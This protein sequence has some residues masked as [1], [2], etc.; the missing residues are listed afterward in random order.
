LKTANP[1]CVLEWPRFPLT[2]VRFCW[3]RRNESQAGPMPD[4]CET[5]DGQRQRERKSRMWPWFVAGFLMV[6]IGMSLTVTTYSLHP[7]GRAVVACK[8]WLYYVFETRRALSR[9]SNVL[10]PATRS[11]CAAVVKLFQHVLW[12]AVGGAGMLGI[13]WVF[14]R[15]RE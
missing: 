15:L 14:R 2:A 3:V 8:L 4:Q 10:G 9:S 6:F 7:S 11:L 5:G 12:S 13:G 1:A